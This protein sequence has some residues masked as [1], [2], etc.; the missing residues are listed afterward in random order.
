MRSFK[1]YFIAS[2]FILI[3]SFVSCSNFFSDDNKAQITINL[4][5]SSRNNSS[6]HDYID[7]YN[8]S[9]FQFPDKF[10]KL[11]DIYKKHN[12]NYEEYKNEPLYIE[13]NDY[14]HNFNT[15]DFIVDTYKKDDTIHKTLQPGLWFFT[16]NAE[17]NSNDI[18]YY[19]SCVCS[20]EAGKNVTLNLKMYVSY[21]SRQLFFKIGEYPMYKGDGLFYYKEI[22]LPD[23]V[24]ITKIESDESFT[25]YY[26]NQTLDEIHETIVSGYSSFY[27]NCSF[28]FED[29]R[30]TS[31]QYYATIP[32]LENNIFYYYAGVP[33]DLPS[34]V[35]HP[36]K[37]TFSNGNII[38]AYWF[39]F[40]E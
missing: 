33:D 31:P 25:N 32:Y 19:G 15:N 20:L 40:I 24:S 23:D 18:L 13:F 8:L 38:N 14:I 11:N 9:Y 4:G 37:I 27:E 28:F 6:P 30:V 10:L 21:N 26:S 36:I 12:N 29:P 39:K 5:N 35:A 2:T 16:I 34:G 1:P 3:I 22:I 17:D 7:H